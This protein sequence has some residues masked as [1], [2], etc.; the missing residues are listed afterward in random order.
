MKTIAIATSLLIA[1]SASATPIVITDVRVTI[2][3][4]QFTAASVGWHL[5]ATLNDGESLVLTQDGP[6]IG[7]DAG[8]GFDFDT[9]DLAPGVALVCM[10]VNGV[11]GCTLDSQQI[12]TA[13]G[14]D[15]G[16]LNETH[17]WGPRAFTGAIGWDVYFGY[18]D[19]IRPDPACPNAFCQPALFDCATY[20]QGAASVTALGDERGPIFWDAGAIKIVNHASPVPEPASLALL[21]IGLFGVG[22]GV[23]RRSLS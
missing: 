21:G 4:S 22:F 19:N 6:G 12:L 5:P 2:G 18:V 9:S 16:G 13:G 1:S 7:E 14:N 10:T 20:L 11:S 3:T 15:A 23:R 17:A 8:T